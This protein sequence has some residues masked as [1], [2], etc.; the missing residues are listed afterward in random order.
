MEK[1]FISTFFWF[2]SSRAGAFA[3]TLKPITGALEA[4]ANKMSLSVIAPTPEY[5][6]LI[7]TSSFP[8]LF[9]A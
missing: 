9:K 8:T 6:T 3:L 1:Y 7:I 4:S 2:A 5:K